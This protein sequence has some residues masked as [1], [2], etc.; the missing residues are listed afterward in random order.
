MRHA[1]VEEGNEPEE[2][3]AKSVSGAWNGESA[4]GIS[5]I[6]VRNYY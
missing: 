4:R 1:K 2:V 6:G 3:K 5:P